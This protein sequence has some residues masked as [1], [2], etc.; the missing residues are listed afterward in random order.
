V[1]EVR[2]MVGSPWPRTAASCGRGSGGRTRLQPADPDEHV[3]GSDV[4]VVLQRRLGRPGD[5]L[6]DRCPHGCRPVRIGFA[7]AADQSPRT[8]DSAEAHRSVGRGVVAVCPPSAWYTGWS[9]STT[10]CPR[11]VILLAATWSSRLST[12]TGAPCRRRPGPPRAGEAPAPRDGRYPRSRDRPR[13]GEDGE[14]VVV[15]RFGEQVQGGGEVPARDLAVLAARPDR[16]ARSPGA[17]CQAVDAS[18]QW[19]ASAPNVAITQLLHGDI[20]AYSEAVTGGAGSVAAG[21][22]IKDFALAQ[23]RRTTSS[24]PSR[25]ST[26]WP[27]S[28]A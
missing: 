13:R 2:S 8:H 18:V 23:P 15:E 20:D 6:S 27:T 9:R 25:A 1:R 19:N 24:W 26:P 28:R 22:D 17:R 10:S 5:P 7:H 3:D 4:A 16:S 12:A 11:T 14:R 21:V